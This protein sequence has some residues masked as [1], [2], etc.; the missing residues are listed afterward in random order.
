MDS[1]VVSVRIK[2]ETKMALEKDGVDVEK[3]VKDFLVQRAAQI[4]LKKTVERM[5]RSIKKNVKPSKKGFAVRSVREDRD[6]AH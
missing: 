5:A 6:A 3:A 1:V 2:S 4:E